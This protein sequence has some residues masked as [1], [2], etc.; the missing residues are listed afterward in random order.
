LVVT[1]E[2][3]YVQGPI[4]LLVHAVHIDAEAEQHLHLVDEVLL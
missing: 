3:S 1:C 4:A 2:A